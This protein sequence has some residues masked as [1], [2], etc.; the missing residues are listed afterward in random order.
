[1]NVTEADIKLNKEKLNA[2]IAKSIQVK[3]IKRGL[4]HDGGQYRCDVYI[5]GK[6]A[7]NY[8][9]DDCGAG[10]E[11]TY[12]SDKTKVLCEAFFEDEKIAHLIKTST[13]YEWVKAPNNLF[14]KESDVITLDDAIDS[15]LYLAMNQKNKAD[16]LKTLEKSRLKGFVFGTEDSYNTVYW[17][18]RTL[19]EMKEIIGSESLQKELNKITAGLNN[20]QSV[21]NTKEQLAELGLVVVTK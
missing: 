20:G 1:M 12:F 6:K 18:K 8:L 16:S 15:V 19:E 5:N 3:K 11:I 21:L 14:Y 10:S 17:P 7:I 9:S 13:Q 4:G 2:I